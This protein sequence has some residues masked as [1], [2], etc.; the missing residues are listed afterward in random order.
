M[1]ELRA[2]TLSPTRSPSVAT[3]LW[4][5]YFYEPER[6]S[7][8]VVFR[9]LP[10]RP[11]SRMK[12]LP[13]WLKNGYLRL[14]DPIADWLVRRRVHPNTITIVGTIFMVAGGLLYGTGHIMTRGRLPSITALTHVLRGTVARRGRMTAVLGAFLE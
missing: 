7:G 5:R 1:V 13:D 9:G 3:S 10:G 4:S 11:R 8:F 6:S 2:R 12:I 14:M